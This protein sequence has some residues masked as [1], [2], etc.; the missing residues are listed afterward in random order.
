MGSR[1]KP[2]ILETLNT[3]KQEHQSC[4]VAE[5]EGKEAEFIKV[6]HSMPDV[7]GSEC[8]MDDLKHIFGLDKPLQH[9][10]SISFAWGYDAAPDVGF[11]FRYIIW[12]HD[13]DVCVVKT[14]AMVKRVMG[15]DWCIPSWGGNA[16]KSFW[17][18]ANIHQRQ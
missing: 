7:W 3:L 4:S 5:R 15:S 1:V 9:R 6:L 18:G 17:D 14:K 11:S 12:C 2:H 10:G 16:A 13:L 8:T